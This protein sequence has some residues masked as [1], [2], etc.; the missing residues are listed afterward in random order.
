[1]R[2]DFQLAIILAVAAIPAGTAL[3]AAPEYLHLT[4]RAL[5]AAFWGGIALTA[6]LIVLAV[7]IALRGEAQAPQKGHGQRMIAIL[8]MAFCGTGFM[9]FAILF[10]VQRPLPAETSSPVENRCIWAPLTASESDNLYEK[11]RGI[12]QHSFHIACSRSECSDL[13]ISFDRLFKRLGWPSFI[14]DGGFL[15]TGVTGILINPVDSGAKSLKSAIETTTILRPDLGSLRG[16]DVTSPI[17]LVIGTKPEILASAPTHETKEPEVQQAHTGSPVFRFEKTAFVDTKLVRWPD[18]TESGLTESRYFLLVGNA[19]DTGRP[20]KNVKARIFFLAQEPLLARVKETGELSTD[21]RHGEWAFFEIGK[22][23]SHEA[24]SPIS[25]AVIYSEDEKKRYEH[26]RPEHPRH[27]EILLPS[28]KIAYGINQ[29][30]EHSAPDWP[31][32]M[33]VTADDAISLQL[34]VI[35]DLTSKTPVTFQEPN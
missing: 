33:V 3:M 15:A 32:S 18:G 30:L 12:G 10:F 1:M 4:G 22:M 21:I 9:A 11:L 16:K 28:G 17:M 13:A 27:L 14:G 7:A 2:R 34:K 31:M 5:A 19:M 24:Q 8:G 26:L 23:I 25:G 29:D 35:L 6:V 20:L